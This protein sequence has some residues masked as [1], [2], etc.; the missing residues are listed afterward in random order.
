[1]MSPVAMVRMPVPD[2]SGDAA[3]NNDEN[4]G[5][6]EHPATSVTPRL[7]SALRP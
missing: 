4:A 2:D 1:M 6:S 3:N 7:R 5:S